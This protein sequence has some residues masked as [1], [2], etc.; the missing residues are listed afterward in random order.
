MI[1]LRKIR[2]VACSIDKEVNSAQKECARWRKLYSRLVSM[3]MSAVTEAGLFWP[4]LGLRT[5]TTLKACSGIAMR[6]QPL[7]TTLSSSFSFLQG[8][9]QA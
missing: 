4:T 3:R 1:G 9:S 2:W 7:N 6:A 8:C 5:S